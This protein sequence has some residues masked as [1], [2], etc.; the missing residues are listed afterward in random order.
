M[1]TKINV[2]SIADMKEPDTTV[3]PLTK[4]SGHEMTTSHIAG[5]IEPM[6]VI[7]RLILTLDASAEIFDTTAEVSPH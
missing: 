2:K 3:A 1:T 5:L 6:R 4:L 7:D